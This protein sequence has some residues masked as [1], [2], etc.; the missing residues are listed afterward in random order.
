MQSSLIVV[1]DF[2]GNPDAVRDFAL[3]SEFN[4]MGALNYPGWESQ[5]HFYTDALRVAFESIIGRSIDVETERF[6]WG[7]FR[8]VT[9]STGRLV[10][11]HADS[12]VDWAAMVYLSPNMP[13]S[14]GTGFYRHRSTGLSGPPTDCEAREL[15]YADASSFEQEVARRDMADLEKWELMSSIA[16]VY[17]RL[18]LFRGCEAYHAPLGG[19]GT[20]PEDARITHNFFFN[21]RRV[22]V[23]PGRLIVKE[24][25][26]RV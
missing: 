21:E 12:I 17:N 22:E 25:G 18:V 24:I 4:S 5:K 13:T 10:K 3:R 7:G 19:Y 8:I 15:G 1:D 9:A 14:A 11:V 16:P 26:A 2:Y 23:T 6:T 20:C